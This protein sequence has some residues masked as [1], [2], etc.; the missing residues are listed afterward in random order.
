MEDQKCLYITLSH[1][2]L[3]NQSIM[4]KFSQLSKKKVLFDQLHNKEK[5]HSFDY[6]LNMSFAFINIYF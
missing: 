2:I 6:Q 3:I 5:Q 1:I 4:L